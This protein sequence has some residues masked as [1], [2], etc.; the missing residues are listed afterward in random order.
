MV[1]AE[2]VC[3]LALQRGAGEPSPEEFLAFYHCFIGFWDASIEVKVAALFGIGFQFPCKFLL[4]VLLKLLLNDPNDCGYLLILTFSEQLIHF[5][6]GVVAR[7]QINEA[8]QSWVLF[9]AF[10]ALLSYVFLSVVCDFFQHEGEDVGGGNW[11]A[12]EGLVDGL[13]VFLLLFLIF[14][15]SDT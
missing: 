13:N 11:V 10:E 5:F 14:P 7:V 2:V 4:V 3:N 15:M 1:L 9:L 12:F 8:L 6:I